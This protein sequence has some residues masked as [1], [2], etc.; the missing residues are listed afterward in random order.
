MHYI[1]A[2]AWR[3]VVWRGRASSRSCLAAVARWQT[4]QALR[5]WCVRMSNRRS[6][7]IDDT[8]RQARAPQY[9]CLRARA[10][11]NGVWR[12]LHHLATRR[13]A[14]PRGAS[15]RTAGKKPAIDAEYENLR[16]AKPYPFSVRPDKP[17][18][19]QDLMAIHREW[20]AGTKYAP[21]APGNIVGGP[22]DNP[23]RYE[24]SSW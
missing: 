8:S 6:P 9:P 3:S 13:R 10:C 21:T 14:D 12:F 15:S 4:K 18:T 2:R 16:Y 1:V 17:Q 22:W 24:C 5:A 11:R 19:P 23:V 7:V 20:Y